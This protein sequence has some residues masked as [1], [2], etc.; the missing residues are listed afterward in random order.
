MHSHSILRFLLAGLTVALIA[1][2]TIRYTNAA[3]RI[4]WADTSS[5]ESQVVQSCSGFDIMSSYT[6]NRVHN[7]VEEYRHGIVIERQQVEFAGA[8]GN[9]ATGLSYSYDGHY[10]YV[11]DNDKGT[12]TVS[13][14][15]MRFEVGT[16]GMFSY[17]SKEL[18]FDVANDPGAIVKAIVPAMLHMDACYLLQGP[19]TTV[20]GIPTSEFWSTGITESA[21][22]AEAVS[23]HTENS[24]LPQTDATGDQLTPW[25]E[26]DPCDTTPPGKPC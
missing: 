12:N 18:G 22:P 1:T 26:L 5:Q 2:A 9:S 7:L 16:P 20:A 4:T 14:L 3:E 6:A 21:A 19:V 11:T 24:A 10:T 25:T 8:L 23:I 17:E 13:N 15:K